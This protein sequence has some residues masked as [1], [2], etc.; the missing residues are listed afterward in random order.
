VFDNPQTRAKML[1]LLREGAT[2]KDACRLLPINPTTFYRSIERDKEFAEQVDKAQAEGKHH[3][4]K[5]IHTAAKG[6]DAKASMWWLERVHWEEYARRKPE[7]LGVAQVLG[8]VMPVMAEIVGCVPEDKR[9]GVGERLE[10]MAEKL[11]LEAKK[12]G[13]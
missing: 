7:Q 6:G 12:S 8:I 5:V 4:I 10:L 9:Q 13:Y 11:Q 3:H 1:R 2:A